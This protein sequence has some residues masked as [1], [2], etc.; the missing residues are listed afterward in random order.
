VHVAHVATSATT[1]A[2]VANGG[3]ACRERLLR[4]LIMR[5][6][7]KHVGRKGRDKEKKTKNVSSP[8]ACPGEEEEETMPPQNST[9]SSLSLSVFFLKCMERRRFAQNA[10]F[11]LNENWSSQSFN[12]RAFCILVIGLGFL[13]LSP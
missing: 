9:V 1:P 2:V 5:W 8:A 13:Q 12:L 7:A 4:H 10:P 3:V 11:H 6:V